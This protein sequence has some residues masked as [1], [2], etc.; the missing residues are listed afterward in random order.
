MQLD[1]LAAD[2]Q[3]RSHSAASCRPWI[4]HGNDAQVC[5]DEVPKQWV[6]PFEGKGRP[7]SGAAKPPAKSKASEGSSSGSLQGLELVLGNNRADRH[8]PSFS[9]PSPSI[10]SS[11]KVQCREG[12][13]VT[14]QIYCGLEGHGPTQEQSATKE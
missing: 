9:L 12:V 11:L 1:W 14:C 10:L 13:H 8:A 3:R 4:Q 7:S 2:N 6:P 5:E